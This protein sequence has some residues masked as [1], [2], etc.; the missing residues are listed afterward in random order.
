MLTVTQLI[1]SKSADGPGERF[2]SDWLTIDQARIDRF[3][4]ATNDPDPLHI[5]PDYA[6]RFSR[7][8]TTISFG[9]LTMSL[10]SFFYRSV[11][12]E[13]SN[14]YSLNYGFDRV[15]LT[16]PVPVGSR[17][18]AV[19]E[20]SE[21]KRRAAGEVVTIYDVT[22]EVEGSD[23]PALVAQW[24]TLWVEDGVERSVS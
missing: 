21:V 6:R 7:F 4:E 11:I 16:A 12:R 20:L 23:R 17:I 22:I 15:R 8:G 24:L 5:D 9:F 13:P 10:L 14:G 2:V 18:R 19:F 1:E 3:A